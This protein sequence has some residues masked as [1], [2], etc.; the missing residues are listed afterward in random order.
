MIFIVMRVKVFNP[1]QSSNIEK[2]YIEEIGCD[3]IGE[4]NNKLIKKKI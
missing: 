3:K 1:N 2:L 4:K